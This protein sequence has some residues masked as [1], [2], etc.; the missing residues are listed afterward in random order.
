MEKTCDPRSSLIGRVRRIILIKGPSLKTFLYLFNQVQFSKIVKME[1]SFD[2]DSG[3]KTR[4]FASGLS[5]S[6]I[7]S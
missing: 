3:S 7:H 1:F 4:I 5:N 2:Y 6:T